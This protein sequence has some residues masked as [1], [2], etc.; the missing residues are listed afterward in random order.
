MPVEPTYPPQPLSETAKGKRPARDDG[1]EN[2]EDYGATGS[3]SRASSVEPP[4][5]L[6][7][8]P[9]TIRFTEGV[10]DLE[11]TVSEK[12]TVRDVKKKVSPRI[13]RP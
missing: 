8:R 12:E 4:A 2:D 1:D 7:Q 5:P 6:A 9:L 10:E 13:T 11:I 3:T